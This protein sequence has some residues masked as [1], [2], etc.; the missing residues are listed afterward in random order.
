M[1]LTIDPTLG[2]IDVLE[3]KRMIPHR[4]PFL[5]IDRV[6]NV[7]PG[8]GAVGLKNVTVNEPFFEGHFPARPVMPGVLI[9]EAMAQTSAVLVVRTMGLVDHDLLVYFMS[10]DRARFRRIVTP[11][12]Q[13]ELHVTVQRGRGKIWRFVA[14]AKVAGAL[15]AEAEYMAMIVEPGDEGQG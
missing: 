13:L 12:D 3:I 7:R 5:L 10:V 14:E 1:P 6:V 2:Q 9:I 15:C 8:A 4:Y 11:G